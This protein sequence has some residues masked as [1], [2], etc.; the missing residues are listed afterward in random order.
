MTCQELL[1]SMGQYI[2]SQSPAAQA[3]R[4]QC[5][6]L[7]EHL[8][9]CPTCRVV[10]DNLRGTIAL[11]NHDQPL[12]LPPGFEIKLRQCLQ[13]RWKQLHAKANMKKAPNGS[14]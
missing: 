12:A 14:R 7:M 1:L 13:E 10:V 11:Y 2:E 6:A 4:A 9:D 3:D 8:A 5:Q